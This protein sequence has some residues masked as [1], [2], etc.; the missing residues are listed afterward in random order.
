MERLS[1]NCYEEAFE[2]WL[3]DNAVRY[4]RAGAAVR[5][6]AG[7]EPAKSFDFLLYGRG[8]AGIIAEVKGRRFAGTTLAGLAGLECWVTTDDV[9]GLHRWRQELGGECEA[10]FVFAYK[11][12][13]IDV[14]FDGRRVFDFGGD[15]YI[16]FCIR[17]DDYRS[18][19]RLRSLKWRT[20]T[21][22]ADRFRT[23]AVDPD[24]I[25]L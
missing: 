16:F 15:K 9:D 5:A 3:I 11:I 19:M 21:L 18:S 7:A 12:E 23:C 17:L 20:V 14:D 4:A 10:V 2:N 24:K 13:N 6:W 25:L 8:R 1:A 22:P